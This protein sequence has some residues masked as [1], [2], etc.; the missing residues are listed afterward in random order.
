MEIKV[1][2]N[3]DEYAL[4]KQEKP[5]HLKVTEV[6]FSPK[7]RKFE[8]TY[9][10][11]YVRE[12]TPASLQEFLVHRGDLFAPQPGWEVMS[13]EAELGDGGFLSTISQI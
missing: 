3:Q 1:E 8:R 2:L 10:I 5:G 12:G 9:T 6:T 13:P 4:V 11:V 7:G